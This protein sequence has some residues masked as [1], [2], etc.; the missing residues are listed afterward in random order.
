VIKSHFAANQERIL[1]FLRFCVVG[2]T[3]GA[4]WLL[5]NLKG[6]SGLQP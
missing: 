3:V 1:R 2:A 5:R 6:F 4:V